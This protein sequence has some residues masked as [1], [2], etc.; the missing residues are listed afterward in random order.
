MVAYAATLM[1]F[2]EIVFI[3]LN[4]NMLIPLFQMLFLDFYLIP[5][6]IF[7]VYAAASLWV[8][9][10]KTPSEKKSSEWQI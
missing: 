8:V 2:L 4:G 5:I 3:P 7:I 6:L 9:E 1:I 10:N